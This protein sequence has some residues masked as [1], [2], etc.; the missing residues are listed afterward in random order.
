MVYSKAIQ[1][2]AHGSNTDLLSVVLWPQ[3][4]KM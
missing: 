4:E 2:A 3:K 1:L